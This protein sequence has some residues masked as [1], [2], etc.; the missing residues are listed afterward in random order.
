MPWL[1]AIVSVVA[2]CAIGAIMYA[3]FELWDRRR[4]RNGQQLPVIDYSI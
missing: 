1:N 2:P 4:R 3:A